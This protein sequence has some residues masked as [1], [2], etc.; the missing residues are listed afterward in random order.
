MG[1]RHCA[2]TKSGALHILR[3][4]LGFDQALFTAHCERLLELGYTRASAEG[5]LKWALGRMLLHRGDPDLNRIG[6]ADLDE[7]TTA[8]LTF[9]QRLSRGEPVREFYAKNRHGVR[10]RDP[11]YSYLRTVTTRIH[12]AHRR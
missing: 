3:P 2:D 11:A 5:H 8:A 12:A 7:L 1:N 6:Q 9:S 10:T 4:A